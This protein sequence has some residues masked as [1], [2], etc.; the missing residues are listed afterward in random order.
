[1]CGCFTD[2]QKIWG[3][4]LSDV[5]M[6]AIF[7]FPGRR[8]KNFCLL[9]DVKIPFFIKLVCFEIYGQGYGEKIESLIYILDQSFFT[10]AVQVL[11]VGVLK[12]LLCSD[13]L[14]GIW[15]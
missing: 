3:R 5:H 14:L 11:E 9:A 12:G 13:S 2:L 8:D 6:I 15:L 7:C 10:L 1:M 4:S